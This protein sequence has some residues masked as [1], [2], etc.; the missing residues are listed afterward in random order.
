MKERLA[1]YKPGATLATRLLG[2]PGGAGEAHAHQGMWMTDEW[3]HSSLA[4][5]L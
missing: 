2:R 1:R 3:V 4:T 5:R